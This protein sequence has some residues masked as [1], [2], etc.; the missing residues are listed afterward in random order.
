M[1]IKHKIEKFV[2]REGRRPRILVSNMGKASR[3]Q[4]TKL[5]AAI[6]AEA[7]F[8]VDLSPL[9]QT[10]Q[11]TARMASENDVHAV[12]F[13]GADNQHNI[14]VTD[15]VKA[16][17]TEGFE[18]V[19]ILLGGSIPRSDYRSLNAAGVDLI[20][21]SAGIDSDEINDVLDLFMK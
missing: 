6:F 14:M 20:L 7:G 1:Q 21:S 15:L 18:N 3:D 2:C 4:D 10:P 8:D 17:K 13:L 19:K 9:Q 11:G 12:C 16:L 5:I